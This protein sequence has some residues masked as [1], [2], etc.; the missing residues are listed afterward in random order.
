MTGREV[1][2]DVD[3]DVVTDMALVDSVQTATIHLPVELIDIAEWLL[4]M[5]DAEYQRCAVPDHIAAG[6]S[7][8]DDGRLMS[9]N[10]EMIGGSLM[11]QHYVF[12]VRQPNH[13]NLVSLSDVQTPTGWSKARVVWDLS[14]SAIDGGSCRYTNRITSYATRAFL[15]T[16]EDSGHSF[17]RA[18]AV[19]QAATD[20]HNRRE[21]PMYAASLARRFRSDLHGAGANELPD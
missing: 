13:C 9:I 10:V 1:S 2:A 15:R 12:E 20:D 19:R 6:S 18:A 21:T 17:E 5:P 7:K 3:V 8:T 4:N 16:L 11:V 14:V